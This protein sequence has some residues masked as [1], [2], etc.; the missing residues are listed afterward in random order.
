MGSE[1]NAAL[2]KCCLLQVPCHRG[3]AFSSVRMQAGL[4]SLIW[5][6][7]DYQGREKLRYHSNGEH[8]SI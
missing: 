6:D 1:M 7:A 3:L 5:E 8:L 2:D 4:P